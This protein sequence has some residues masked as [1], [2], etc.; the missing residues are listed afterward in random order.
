MFLTGPTYRTGCNINRAVCQNPDSIVEPN[1]D[2]PPCRYLPLL[3]ESLIDISEQTRTYIEFAE[4]RI[5][6][7]RIHTVCKEDKNEFFL[8]VYPK[9][10]AGKAEVSVDLGRC[11]VAGRRI[12]R[13]FR[14]GLVKTETTTAC[15]TF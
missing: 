10:S 6:T 12:V 11:L 2:T 4:C 8:G 9:N 13:I 1:Y 5:I 14:I 3:Q 7:S 15:R